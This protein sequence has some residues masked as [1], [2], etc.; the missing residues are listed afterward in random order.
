[1]EIPSECA[2]LS[3][4]VLEISEIVPENFVVDSKA[5][6]GGL[7]PKGAMA[8]L[9]AGFL[10]FSGVLLG[11]RGILLGFVA[12]IAIASLALFP[13]TVVLLIPVVLAGIFLGFSHP[14]VP[15]LVMALAFLAG[16]SVSN[17]LFYA[18]SGDH[19]LFD[20]PII[21][22]LVP[23]SFVVC[24][25]G[26]AYLSISWDVSR[27]GLRGSEY[28]WFR[29]A[30][31]NMA[32]SDVIFWGRC[33]SEASS[34]QERR[35]IARAALRRGCTWRLQEMCAALVG[36]RGAGMTL[37]VWVILGFVS[38]NFFWAQYTAPLAITVVIVG[39]ALYS[40]GARW[41]RTFIAACFTLA[42]AAFVYF[43]VA[44][45][46][47][48]EY[49]DANKPIPMVWDFSGSALIMWLVLG[50]SGFCVSL[51]AGFQRDKRTPV[52]TR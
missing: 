39:A 8:K 31:L 21:F 3:N 14:I 47:G 49:A 52:Q 13:L 40:Q 19:F 37:L 20:S 51:W 22:S 41:R 32:S 48:F 10:G 6:E 17:P 33:F 9:G 18:P 24:V 26:M 25:L 46:I 1:M 50:L 28:F 45:G 16:S 23:L 29:L 42:T 4:E 43:A 12:W 7:S 34:R 36:D 30:E 38:W 11:E 2:G 35:R 15:R 44:F 5:E 27:A